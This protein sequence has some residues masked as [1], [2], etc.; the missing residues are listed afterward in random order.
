MH[1]HRVFLDPAL[2]AEMHPGEPCGRGTACV[3][4]RRRGRAI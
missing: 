3:R 1:L 2:L 4:I